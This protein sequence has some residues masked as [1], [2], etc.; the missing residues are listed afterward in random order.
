LRYKNKEYSRKFSGCL[1]GGRREGRC[2]LVEAFSGRGRVWRRDWFLKLEWSL[3]CLGDIRE[4]FS[5]WELQEVS[6]PVEASTGSAFKIALKARNVE[7][8]C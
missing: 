6:I 2:L 7:E 1:N 5:N 8:L 4:L 3:K